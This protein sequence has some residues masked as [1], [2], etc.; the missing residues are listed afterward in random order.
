MVKTTES[1]PSAATKDDESKPT[2]QPQSANA[3]DSSTQ[4]TVSGLIKDTVT[5]PKALITFIPLVMML[6]GAEGGE[7][8]K[9]LLFACVILSML[10][11][12]H[13]TTK[14]ENSEWRQ[15]LRRE[16]AE[17]ER[18][19]GISNSQQDKMKAAFEM[20]IPPPPAVDLPGEPSAKE[21]KES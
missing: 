15:N 3:D 18:A 10:V 6:R 5:S 20:G 16:V 7:E 8:T 13:L 17:K 21:K 2:A 9:A 14:L 11:G 4:V 19:E 1:K 12:A